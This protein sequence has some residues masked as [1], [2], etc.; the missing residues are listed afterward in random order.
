MAGIGFELNKILGKRSYTSLFKAYAY[1]GLIGS[2]PWIIAVLSL[3]VLG[4][5]ISAFGSEDEVRLFFVTISVT[6]ALSLV[7]TGPIQLVYTRHAADLEFTNQ[8][9][10]IFPTFVFTLA[11]QSIL[12]TCIGIIIYVFLIPT[13]LLFQ[14]SAV[15]LL[16]TV[17]NIW[18]CGILLAG[19]KNYRTILICFTIGF[20]ASV[21]CSYYMAL[22]YGIPSAML[23]FAIGHLV[24]FLF[25]LA[26]IYKEMGSFELS[27]GEFLGAYAKYWDLAVGGF[28]YNFGIWIDKFLFWWT[29]PGSVQVMGILYASPVFDKVVY[30][31]FITIVP[32]MTVFL[33]KLETEFAD[34][35]QAFFQHVLKKGTLN[36]IH[37]LKNDMV[38][39]LR[40]GFVLLIKVQGLFTILMVLSTER[41]LQYLGLGSVQAGVFQIALL[42]VFLLVVFLALLTILYYLD[43][44]RDAMWCTILFTATNFLI[45]SLTIAGGQRWFGF[46]FFVAAGVALAVAAM[47]VNKHLDNL[48]YD[49]FSSQPLY[50]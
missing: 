7:V 39:A 25:L 27:G 15:M 23:G 5:T 42:G 19:L 48:V 10:K 34:K 33:L 31:S 26:A 41:L 40:S 50:G 13:D 17:C 18:L 37:E 1:A 21:A 8:P 22:V 12:F 38:D 4:T 9:E 11:W 35:N 29:D 46:G 16:T 3:G 2:G 47:R 45:T 49:T 30:F 28:F 24:M 44:R 36:Q 20:L 32:G 14:L 43:K 6:Y